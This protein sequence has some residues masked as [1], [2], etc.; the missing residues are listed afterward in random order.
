V[1]NLRIRDV[2]EPFDEKLGSRPEPVVLTLTEKRG[3]VPQAQRFKKRLATED[4]SGYKVVCKNDIAFNPYLLWAGAIAQ[5]IEWEE[6]I[7]SPAYPTFR[8]R[9]GF[10]PR[11]VSYRLA[12]EPL[13]KR[14]DSI[15]FGAV[16]RRRRAATEDFL[17]LEFGSVPS[18][19]DQRRIAE[20]LDR[21]DAL[22][23]KRLKSIA[24]I[25]MLLK[26]VFI[27]MF[28]DP[29][30]NP[31]G[32]PL[33]SLPEFYPDPDGGTRCGPFGSAL[34]KSDIVMNG[35]PLWNMDNISVDGEMQLPF[36]AWVS[37]EKAHYLSGYKVL[38]GDIL[39]SR[40]GTVG[41]M[42]VVRAGV[43]ESLM[44]TN[45]IRLRLGKGLA[46]EFFVALMT[47]CKGR[48][49]RLKTGPDG[50]F[51][52]MS[53][54]VL[55]TLSFPYPPFSLQEKWLSRSSAIRTHKVML[56]EHLDLMN[57]QFESMTERV[58]SQGALG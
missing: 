45:L 10:D 9:D 2:L 29:K 47:Y 41:K 54:G 11:F 53:T 51:T 15:S 43:E 33:R 49:G 5:N 25:D 23:A 12:S 55:D 44:T 38:D 4:T 26:S 7:I 31:R 24:M 3:F 34:K 18:L 52:H 37:E 13:K 30:E 58:F 22:R 42:C 14:F 50:T 56:I 36:R 17:R 35:V 19:P 20:A 6:A 28:G 32:F 46:P 1:T 16:P 27:E 21:A 48:V 40:A 57:R 8:V 39:I